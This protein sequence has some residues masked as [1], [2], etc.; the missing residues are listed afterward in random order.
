MY[1]G[2]SG[3]CWH[4]E[5]W[6]PRI[7]ALMKAV[8]KQ[9]SISRHLWLVVFGANLEPEGFMKV[10]GANQRTCSLK[11]QTQEFLLVDTRVD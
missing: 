9:A 7:E 4:S 1:A 6:T 10:C 3:Y 2:F 11:R 8:V 5:G